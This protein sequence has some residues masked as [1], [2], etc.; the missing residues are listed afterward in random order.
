MSGFRADRLSVIREFRGLSQNDL[1]SRSGVDV[2]R[3]SR[4][5]KNGE[6]PSSRILGQLADALDLTADFLLGRD[7]FDGRPLRELAVR[8]SFE[9]FVRRASVAETDRERLLRMVAH[10]RAPKTVDEWTAIHELTT[11][12]KKLA[13]HSR[14]AHAPTPPPARSQQHNL[15][16]VSKKRS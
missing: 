11:T 8:E 7:N 10:E 5:E 2:S 1:A 13:A 6:E 4:Y 9:L 15:K 3:I 16:A 14:A 12:R